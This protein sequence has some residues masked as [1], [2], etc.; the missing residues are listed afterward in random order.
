MNSIMVSL[1]VHTFQ[2][3]LYNVGLVASAV[4]TCR[5][6]PVFLQNVCICPQVHMVLL[7][8][9]LILTIVLP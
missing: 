4:R 9:R 2:L 7:P 3:M 5:H 6:I 8:R 1:T